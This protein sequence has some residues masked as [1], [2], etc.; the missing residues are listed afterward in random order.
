[1]VSKKIL[2]KAFGGSEILL[3]LGIAL[4]V[5]T[6]LYLFFRTSPLKRLEYQA[7]SAALSISTVLIGISLSQLF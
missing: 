4:L 7:I 6:I 2:K 3:F 1:M 5:L